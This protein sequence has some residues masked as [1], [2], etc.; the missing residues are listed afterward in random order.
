MSQETNQVDFFNMSVSDQLLA[1][2]EEDMPESYEEMV[3]S[4]MDTVSEGVKVSFAYKESRKS[5]CVA[6]TLPARVEGDNPQCS[7]FWGGSPLSAWRK[8]FL[9]CFHYNAIHVGW[10]ESYR[11]QI[12]AKGEIDAELKKQRALRSQK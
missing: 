1:Y 9:A 10:G 12:V 4:F 6:I 5:Y 8:A 11:L 2:H 7:T 3:M